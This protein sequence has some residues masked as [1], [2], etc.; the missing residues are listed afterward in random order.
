MSKITDLDKKIKDSIVEDRQKDYG[1]YQ[2]NFTILAEMFTLVLFDSLK[3]RIKPHQVGHII[4]ALKLF[5]STRG[6]KADNY[7][8]LS[9]YNDMAFELHKKDVAKKDKV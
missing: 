4:M 5:R 1:D 7:H 8:D 9:I 6:Y 2:H 3:K